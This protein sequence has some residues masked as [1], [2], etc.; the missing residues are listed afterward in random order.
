M[1]E[2]NDDLLQQSHALTDHFVDTVYDY[3]FYS[4]I[5][6]PKRITQN[7]SSCIDHIWTNIHNKI[8]KNAITTHK[9]AHHLPVIQN[10]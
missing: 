10:T 9:I 2:F 1:G 3:R 4:I 6:K 8:T 7:L 5:N